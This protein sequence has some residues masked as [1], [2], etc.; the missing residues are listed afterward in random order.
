MRRRLFLAAVWY[1][2]PS[3]FGGS[4]AGLIISQLLFRMPWKLLSAFI[5]VFA[6]W[7]LVM[8]LLTAAN[9]AFRVNLRPRR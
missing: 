2:A 8:T 3:T 5:L 7:T 1:Y 4:A 9:T 6:A